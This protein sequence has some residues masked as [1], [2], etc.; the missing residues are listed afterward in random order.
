MLSLPLGLGYLAQSF[1]E[2]LNKL[3]PEEIIAKYDTHILTE[4][5]GGIRLDVI[6]HAK[7]RPLRYTN[8]REVTTEEL[9]EREALRAGF[10]YTV[11]KCSVV[12]MNIAWSSKWKELLKNNFN[13]VLRL[14]VVGGYE[15]IVKSGYYNLEKGYPNSNIIEWHKVIGSVEDD[16]QYEVV[17]IT[18]LYPI[19]KSVA[20]PDM[21]LKLE[22]A[23]KAYISRNQST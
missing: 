3:S 15:R 4:Y 2:D 18:G 22:H 1:L 9:D 21:R 12:T 6:Y 13:P 11:Y 7:I 10:N 14:S 17:Q 19:Y 5:C 20:D 23:V 8:G 16:D